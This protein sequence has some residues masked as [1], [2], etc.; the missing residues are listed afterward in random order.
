MSPRYLLLSATCLSVGFGTVAHAQ[1]ENPDA[2]QPVEVNTSPAAP[3]TIVVQ[4]E[5][6]RGQLDV[7]Q[8]PLLELNEADIAS[9]GAN[10]IEE[11]I[12]AIGPQ[13]GSSQGRGAGRPVFLVNG[14]RIG[15]FR[16][17]RSYPPESVAKVEVMPEE[18]AQR[19]GFAP[20]RRV[21]NIILKENFSSREVELEFE[22]PDRGG[23]WRNGQEFA[24]LT[25]NDGARMNFNLEASDRNQLTEAERDIVQTDGSVSD[26]A[27]DPDPAQFRSLVNDTRE[28]QASINW[29]KAF[30]DSGASV[31]L[32]LQYDR[33]DGTGLSGL[34][35]V[36]LT[37]PD[38]S[39]A[40]RTFGADDPL[41]IRNARDT[42]SSSASY[43]RQL[44]GYQLTATADASLIENET[45]IDRR[46]DTQALIDAAASGTLAI[47]GLIPVQAD[48]G[49]DVARSQTITTVNKATLR[50]SPL[51][52]P[53]GEVST[54]FDLGLNWQRINSEDTRTAGET[55]LSRRQFEGGVSIVVP[56]TS[57]REGFLD[58][59]GSFSLNGSIGFE[60]L[61]DFGSLMD[62]TAGLN[63]AP[64]NR[65]NLAATYVWREAAPGLSDL[66]SP[67]VTTFNV[68]VFDL[69]NGETVLATV[70]S[71]GNPDLLAETQRD[72]RF[73]ANWQIPFWDN[74]TF[75]GEYI[76]NRSSD[77]TRGFPAL[78]EETEAAFPDRVVRDAGGNLVSL[79]RRSVTFDSARSERLVFGL[80]TRGSWGGS[81]SGEADGG[82][83]G[84]S[85]GMRREGRP[86][87]PPGAEGRGPPTPEQ[88][89][90]FMAFREKLCADDGMA[91]LEQIAGAVERGE[92]LSEQ[93]PDLDLTRA[94]RMLERFKG[95]DGSIDRERLGQFRERICSMDPEQ[96]RGGPS[97]G[98]SSEQRPAGTIPNPI[99]G[100]F[101]RDGR[102][103]YFASLNHTIELEN[104]ILIAE[105]GDALDLL[106]G[107]TQSDFGQP[108]HSTQLQAGFFRDGKGI[109]LSGFYTGKA[110]I[111]GNAVTGASPL[112][113]EDLA[114]FNLRVFANL[115]TLTG[116][117]NGPLKGLT[118]SLLAN[119]VLDAQRRIVDDNGDTP[120]RYQ[121]FL[122]DP[123][124]RYLGIDIRKVF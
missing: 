118:V 39:S 18:V 35:G 123:N 86:G 122:I 72:W 57:R 87:P 63:W 116:A 2:A 25:I 27:S 41:E 6:L 97:G 38:G 66:G 46:V 77:V 124:G 26:L 90:R 65:L 20:D 7:E 61:S 78:T 17:L 103:R 15:S 84:P 75:F 45:E 8:P 104:Q 43:S 55:Q 120:L 89:E 48:A 112:F 94:Q 59:L 33:F 56:L 29:A 58:T 114:T 88:R 67:T 92:D 60:D 81:A 96:M 5:R 98:D 42:L 113:F 54:T 9:L 68:P 85:A 52:L 50:G 16:E 102:G 105:G 79:D 74:T 12:E 22:A 4:A 14:I 117:E 3:G 62:W 107:D 49:F 69:V 13:T 31:S 21:V 121:P 119:N 80:F 44:G 110:R 73:S 83:R 111:N 64:T 1:Q 36:L 101:G 32:N 11:L 34:N 115:G 95:E 37:A 106:D 109:R 24:L 93:F 70:T 47:D 51:L 23:Y 10:S 19:F 91:F 100:G 40:F 76:S 82:R 99:S 53:S 108:R 71:G 28:L 30:L